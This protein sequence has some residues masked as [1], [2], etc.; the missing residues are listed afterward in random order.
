M[1]KEKFIKLEKQHLAW[2]LTAF[3]VIAL[4]ILFFFTVYRWKGVAS[5][6]DTLTTILAPFGYG[7][8][9]AW[10]LTPLYNL[11]ENKLLPSFTRNPGRAA[12]GK[13]GVKAIASIVCFLVF[14][15]AIYAMIM[16]IVP[17]LIDSIIVIAS[18]IED[19]VDNL[20]AWATGLLDANPTLQRWITNVFNDWGGNLETWAR[21]TLLPQMTNIVTEVSIGVLSAVKFLW[22]VVIGLIACLYI[23][24]SKDTMAGQSKRFLYGALPAAKANTVLSSLRY[25]NDVFNQFIVG[26]VVDSL[27]I[28]VLC[29]IGVSILRM[30][31]PL[32]ISVVVGVT[33]VIPF[34]GP[35][36]GAIPTA[37]L[38][39]MVSPIQCLYYVIF[40][41]LLQQ[42]DG[43]VIGPKILSGSVGI[44]GFWVLFS[45]MVGGGL[46]GFWGM[47]LGVPVFSCVYTFSR[48]LVHKALK[49]RDLPQD[50]V[51]YE[52]VDR[53]DPETGQLIMLPSYS[54]K[55]KKK[56]FRKEKK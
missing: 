17:Q 44:P 41:F 32:L 1:S 18:N 22:N 34:F 55:P 14:V 52:T 19:Y 42:L 47:L 29:F 7:F 15:A 13:V 12:A 33:N 36:I 9:M 38:V 53:I 21:D 24:N 2:G 28:G 46:F 23:L 39:L 48:W 51:L 30:P 56:Y 16:M 4:S 45:I 31:F 8:I 26:K 10:I 35:F 40:I 11:V 20:S 49:K 3:L 50:S 54:E 27:I 43:N 6:V 37:I 5:W 25:V